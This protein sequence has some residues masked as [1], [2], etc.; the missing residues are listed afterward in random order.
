[1]QIRSDP[2]LGRVLDLQDRINGSGGDQR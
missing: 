2:D 1:V